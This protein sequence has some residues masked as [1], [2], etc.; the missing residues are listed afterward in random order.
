[1]IKNPELQRHGGL[2]PSRPVMPCPTRYHA[3]RGVCAQ[4]QILLP[5]A[6]VEARAGATWG[7]INTIQGTQRPRVGG[8]AHGHGRVGACLPAMS[9]PSI[10]ACI[11]HVAREGY[12]RQARWPPLLRNPL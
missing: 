10:P 11:P 8:Q 6:L 4:E 9:E 5:L 2:L 12:P 1:M 7:A 3:A